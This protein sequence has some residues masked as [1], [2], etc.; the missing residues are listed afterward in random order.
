MRGPRS[1]KFSFLDPKYD[2]EIDV[3][4]DRIYVYIGDDFGVMK[5]WDVTYLLE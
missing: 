5:L 4:K 1:E 3:E 2:D